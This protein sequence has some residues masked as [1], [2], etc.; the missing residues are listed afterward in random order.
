MNQLRGRDSHV[1]DLAAQS[2]SMMLR[3]ARYLPILL[4]GG[5][6]AAWIFVIT[7]LDGG[8]RDTV[9][10]SIG[11]VASGVLLLHFAWSYRLEVNGETLRQHRYFGLG[12]RVVPLGAITGVRVDHRAN[13]VGMVVPGLR[14]LWPAGHIRLTSSVYFE[15]DLRQFISRL[16]KAGVPVDGEVVRRFNVEKAKGA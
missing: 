16:R 4:Y 7:R 6:L 10:A 8:V 1:T 3:P 9:I 11:A 2:R 13:F 12:N 5:S 15:R 14:V